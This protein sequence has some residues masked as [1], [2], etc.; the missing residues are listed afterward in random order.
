M[1]KKIFVLPALV[2]S[3][4]LLTSCYST[5]DIKHAYDR[6]YDEGYESGY[7][8]AEN[9]YYDDD[10]VQD[11]YN[12]GFHDGVERASEY[13]PNVAYDLAGDEYTGWT[14]EEAVAVLADY[15][16]GNASREDA[17]EAA[18][19]LSDYYYTVEGVAENAGEHLD[20]W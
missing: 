8:E 4:S 7:D 17:K 2:L 14:G 15:F 18:R 5:E 12:D 3:L 1:N 16:K 9:D 13:I 19:W 10:Y 6:G 20:P 11:A